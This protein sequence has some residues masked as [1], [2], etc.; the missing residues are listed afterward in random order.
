MPSTMGILNP[1]LDI[2]P[3]PAGPACAVFSMRLADGS[4]HIKE[5]RDAVR[6]LQL[7]PELRKQIL[8]RA[9]FPERWAEDGVWPP[10]GASRILRGTKNSPRVSHRVSWGKPVAFAPRYKKEPRRQRRVRRPM[11]YSNL[12]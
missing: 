7:E 4:L 1:Y 8:V 11:I 2:G 10:H 12:R 3:V 6:D 9:R 5:H